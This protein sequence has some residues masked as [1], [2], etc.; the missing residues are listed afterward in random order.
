MGGNQVQQQ[1]F[2]PAGGGA[3]VPPPMPTQVLYYYAVNG[4][5]QG[6]VSI[7]QLRALFASRTINRESLVWKQGMSNWAALQEV[8]EL[9]SFL[10]GNT[11]P[12]LPNA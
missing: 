6:P 1:N 9:K 11:P 4:T 10:G 2:P 12:P 5:Q 8:E 7:E 3:A